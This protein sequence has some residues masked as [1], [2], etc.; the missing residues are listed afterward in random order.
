MNPFEPSF[1]VQRRESDPM[2]NIIS[3]SV[4]ASLLTYPEAIG[5]I[6][7][8]H[9]EREHQPT[10]QYLLN[11]IDVVNGK[12]YLHTALTHITYEIKP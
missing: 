5:L 11:T 3:T 8:I 1:T 9:E 2:G 6:E 7:R 4:V 10:Q 12:L